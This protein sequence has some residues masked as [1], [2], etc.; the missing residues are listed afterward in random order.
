MNRKGLQ[1]NRLLLYVVAGGLAGT[2]CQINI[3]NPY[4]ETNANVSAAVQA[5]ISTS[6][7]EAVEIDAA[8]PTPAE[9]PTP[10]PVPT[11][12]RGGE[13][14]G[15]VSGQFGP[16]ILKKGAISFA[17]EKPG[18]GNFSASLEG[19]DAQDTLMLALGP[20]PV[21]VRST[22]VVGKSGRYML[23]VNSPG[24]LWK[25]TIFEQ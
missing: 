19:L 15:F 11:P 9:V 17:I 25:I 22:T 23:V 20:D 14:S 2:G 7:P 16:L 6:I 1:R 10:V 8:Q 13:F 5:D 24:L 21:G 18:A 12:S 3:T 4:V